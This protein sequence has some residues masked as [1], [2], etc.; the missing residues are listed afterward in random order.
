MAKSDT[1]MFVFMAR[2]SWRH[3]GKLRPRIVAFYVLF[4]LAN[5]VISLQPVALARLIDTAQQG[6]EG[7]VWRALGWV[8]G[9]AALTLVFWALHGPARVIERRVAFAVYQDFIASIYRKVT[10]MPLRWHQDHHSGGLINRVN[11]AGKALF[12]FGQS[13]FVILQTAMRFTVSL[14]VLACYS[15]WVALASIVTSTL[16]VMLVQRYDRTLIPLE[17]TTNEYEHRLNAALY[18]YIGN[19]VTVLTLRLQG[20]TGSE[21][22]RR[23]DA[24][25]PSFWR[26]T[27][28]NENKW[29]AMLALLVCA[30]TGIVGALCCYSSG[31]GRRVADRPSGCHF[32]VSADDQPVIR[33]GRVIL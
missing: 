9:Y 33:A 18:D 12:T 26:E 27:T 10:L 15:W 25:K 21:I 6:G 11:K 2:L 32:S 19:I 28:V 22:M 20:N 3:A 4:G 16:I 8:L 17:R 30:Q 23:F 29:F 5:I 7:A 13:Q 31:A 14:V 1:N 24:M